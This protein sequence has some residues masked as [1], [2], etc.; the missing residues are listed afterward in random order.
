MIPIH[1]SRLRK[2][3]LVEEILKGV[4]S[5]LEIIE[6]NKYSSLAVVTFICFY[7]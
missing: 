3:I 7:L 5:V 2:L 4:V 1:L 6:N